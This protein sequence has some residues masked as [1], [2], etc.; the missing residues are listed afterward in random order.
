VESRRISWN[1]IKSR[2]VIIEVGFQLGSSYYDKVSES[3]DKVEFLQI[4]E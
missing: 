3:N 4:I 2:P 1:L